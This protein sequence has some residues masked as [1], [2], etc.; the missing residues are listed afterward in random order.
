MN[1]PGVLRPTSGVSISNEV[2]AVRGIARQG[3]MDR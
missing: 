3:P 2:L 1:C